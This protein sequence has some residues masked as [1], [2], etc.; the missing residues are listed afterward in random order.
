MNPT[1]KQF[2]ELLDEFERIS[3]GGADVHGYN[4][5]VWMLDSGI[6]DWDK[7]KGPITGAG[8]FDELKTWEDW[9]ESVYRKALNWMHEWRT[10]QASKFVRNSDD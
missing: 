6:T 3:P 5:K 1:K 2:E 9:R 10:R 8:E 4:G 7:S